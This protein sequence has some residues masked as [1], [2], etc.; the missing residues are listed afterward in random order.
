[1]PRRV[2][3]LSGCAAV[4][5]L[6]L[7]GC[8][9]ERAHDSPPYRAAS[10]PATAPGTAV[11]TERR[12]TAQVT[13]ALDAV[14]ADGGPMVESGVERV[15]DGIHTRPGLTRGVAYEVTVVCAGTGT[16]EM[17]VTPAATGS[18]RPCPLR[19][20]GRLR[21]APGERRAAP[22]RESGAGRRGDGRL[23]DRQSSTA[24]AG[25]G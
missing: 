11:R 3:R 25:V 24:R 21:T 7:T 18:A 1:V 13:A 8:T 9:A 22:R 4:S 20:V 23:A 6:F 10:A 17:V 12:L 16:V 15:S 2:R 5:V 14:T 19:P